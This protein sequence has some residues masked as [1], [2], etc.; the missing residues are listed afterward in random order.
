M[1][2]TSSPATS[3]L[4]WI[5]PRCTSRPSDNHRELRRRLSPNDPRFR[6][7]SDTETLLACFDAW[8]I[9]TTL[10]RANGMFAFAVWDR[11]D[12]RLTLARDRL[13]EKPLYWTN[14]GARLAFCSELKGLVTL[15]EDQA[16]KTRAIASALT[17]LTA[18]GLK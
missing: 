15:P 8:G 17:V 2:V 6:G 3:F 10:Q 18:D 13:G 5:M 14:D 12:R 7:A 4:V 16:E 11:R 1:S 9:E